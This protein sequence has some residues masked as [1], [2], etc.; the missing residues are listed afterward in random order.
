MN[1][2]QK[3]NEKA[4]RLR[5]GESKRKDTDPDK[6]ITIESKKGAMTTKRE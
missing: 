5:S 1:K 3:E 4:Q 6:T 2:M